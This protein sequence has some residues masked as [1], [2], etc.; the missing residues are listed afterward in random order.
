MRNM[1]DWAKGLMNSKKRS[2]L[3]IMTHPGIEMIGRTVYDAVTDGRVH[4]EA[5]KAVNEAYPQSA[6]ATVIMDLTVE[7]EAFGCEISFPK[8]EVPSVVGRLVTDYDSVA[9]LEVPNLT[10]GRV[11]QYLLAN[12]LAAENITDKPTLAGCIGPFSLAGRLFDMTEIMMACYVEPQT[13]EL[14]LQ[15][16]TE[17]IKKYCLELK[18]VGANGVVIAEPA[19]GLLSNDDCLKFATPYLKEIVEAVQDESFLVILHNCGNTGHCTQSMVATGAWAQHF[20]NKIDMVKALEDTPSDLLVMG[21]LDPV[22]LFKMASPAEMKAATAELLE[23][24]KDSPNFVLS[25][26][27]DTPPEVPAANI[28]AFYEAL[29]EFNAKRA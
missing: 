28:A 14:L 26:G 9:K 12:K 17:F 5:I 16:C 23:R 4:F 3:P 25:S 1:Q 22:A 10:K 29:D 27:C 21:N 19:A 15:K 8:N 6:A 13:I 7:A 2:V 24:T 11:P 18:K 20:G